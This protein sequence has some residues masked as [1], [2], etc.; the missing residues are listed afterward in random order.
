MARAD[1]AARIGAAVT[2][3]VARA[4]GRP[5]LV[6]PHPSAPLRARPALAA[7]PGAQVLP[8]RLGAWTLLD[9]AAE[10]H[11]LAADHTLPD[12]IAALAGAAGLI[13]KVGTPAIS[14]FVEGRPRD[15]IGDWITALAATVWTCPFH[16]TPI[17]PAAGLAL[18]AQWRLVATQNRQVAAV[19][20]IPVWKRASLAPL[21]ASIRGAPAFC[22]AP[23]AG[24]KR[25]VKARGALV[26]WASGMPPTLPAAAAA[27]D[28]PLL[29]LE[30]GF[31]RGSGLGARFLPGASWCLDSQG[32]HYDP[33]RP[34]DLECLLQDAEFPAAV[35]ARAV[36]LR[37]TIVRRGISK[38]NLPS[39]PVPPLPIGR[40]IVLVTGQVE[41]DASMRAVTG[42]VRGNLGL[43]RAVRAD[44][45]DAFILYKPHPDLVAGYR[46]GR[47]GQADLLRLADAVVTD[48]PLPALLPHVQ[49]LHTI[50]SLSGF[51]ALMRDVPVT[52]WGQPA[53]AGWGLTED[54]DP[55]A[56]RTR[57]LSLDEL[58]A[59]MLILY[60]RYLDPVTRLPC[61][62]EILLDRLAD[63]SLWRASP[64]TIHRGLQGVVTRFFTRMGGLS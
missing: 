26:A 4:Y 30:D 53:Y 52:A 20:G 23:G 16:G 43:L 40:R 60:P 28:V 45:P 9:A 32:V 34:S 14:L 18:L 6:L 44:E 2:Q 54:R 13:N 8:H 47:I 25:A 31:V 3:A 62:P 37:A 55:I 46:H 61:G 24:L 29:R 27:A 22:T 50:T 15:A 49:A 7:W 11:L 38:Y 10:I 58:I 39:H 57:R 48:T 56:R 51:E 63:A 12:P 17:P 36:A 64:W 42:P 5:V 21:F 19:T 35:L 59:G 33:S 41:D 1:L